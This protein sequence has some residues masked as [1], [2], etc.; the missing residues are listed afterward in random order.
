MKQFARKERITSYELISLLLA[1][2]GLTVN[3]IIYAF[4]CPRF[5]HEAIKIL[6]CFC[7]KKEE[8]RPNSLSGNRV[9]LQQTASVWLKHKTMQHKKSFWWVSH[10]HGW[11]SLIR[12]KELATRR[13]SLFYIRPSKLVLHF[14][15]ASRQTYERQRKK[16]F[17]PRPKG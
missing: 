13:G 14:Q 8:L 2:I 16:L 17:R 7:C 3:P 6:P 9:G 10:I 12:G 4:R 11:V 5:R 1:L 15:W